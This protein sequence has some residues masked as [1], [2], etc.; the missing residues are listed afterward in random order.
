MKLT[1]LLEVE[2]INTYK[3]HASKFATYTY[4]STPKNPGDLRSG[5]FR[6]LPII[7]IW[8]NMKL[9]PVSHKPTKTTLFFQDQGHSP[10]L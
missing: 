4:K 8:G 7:S 9:L 5:Q 6:H 10:N 2:V 3:M 1:G